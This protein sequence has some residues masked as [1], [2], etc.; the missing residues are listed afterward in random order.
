[1]ASGRRSFFVLYRSGGDGVCRLR[2]VGPAPGRRGTPLRGGDA[3]APRERYDEPLKARDF[4]A[5]K[6]AP[7]GKTTIPVERYRIARDQMTRM[8]LYSTRS[9]AFASR[10]SGGLGAAAGTVVGTWNPLGP[11]N[12]GG[13]TRALAINP[14]TPAI[15][16]AGGV[17]GGCGS[18]SMAARPGPPKATTWPTWR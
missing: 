10:R 16:Y 13:R 1:M 11:G 3:N 12:V 2:A 18:P 17:A 7:V 9:G 5:L 15:M 4:F 8:G 14:S 6:R